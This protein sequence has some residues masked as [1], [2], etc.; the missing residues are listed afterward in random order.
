M[1]RR[2]QGPAKKHAKPAVIGSGFHANF[3][4]RF[5]ARRL[6]ARWATDFAAGSRAA[7]EA[8]N[9]GRPPLRPAAAETA[10]QGRERV[11]GARR[12]CTAAS[13]PCGRIPEYTGPSRCRPF[14]PAC[15]PRQSAPSTVRTARTMHV[16][17]PPIPFRSPGSEV[18]LHVSHPRR[19]GDRASEAGLLSE[20]GWASVLGRTPR[21]ADGTLL[22]IRSGGRT[23]RVQKIVRTG[24][25]DKSR[26]V[27]SLPPVGG[28]GF[29]PLA[30]IR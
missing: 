11:P 12:L 20:A 8:Y 3:R 10:Q 30:A 2:L 15:N 23:A 9:T 27:Q 17:C 25:L 4:C 26:T 6:K 1:Q 21:V 22:G 24:V 28:N 19:M 14:A 29:W 16:S 13:M 5:A 18:A 7:R